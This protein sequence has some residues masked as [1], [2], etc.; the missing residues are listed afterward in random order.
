MAKLFEKATRARR[1][2]G[3]S[4]AQ[5][6]DLPR[7]QPDHHQW[8]SVRKSVAAY[9]LFGREFHSSIDPGKVAGL[10]VLHLRHPRSIRCNIAE[11]QPGLSLSSA[12]G[13]RQVS[14]TVKEGGLV[15]W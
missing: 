11:L 7:R 4:L 12:C 14:Y 6:T 10:R 5:V 15:T 13:K 2:T 8:M 9:E 3:V 1:R